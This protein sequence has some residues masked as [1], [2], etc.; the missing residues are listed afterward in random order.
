M[1][2]KDGLTGFGYRYNITEKASN[3]VVVALADKTIGELQTAGIDDLVN[4]ARLSDVMDIDGDVFVLDSTA[5]AKFILD[6]DAHGENGFFRLAQTGETATHKRVYEGA[7]N[8]VVK[9]FRQSA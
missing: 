5:D 7:S 1:K 3:G 4:A 8:A 2:Y 6:L 9:N